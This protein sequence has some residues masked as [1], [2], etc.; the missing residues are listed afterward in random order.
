MPLPLSSA[1]SVSVP[2]MDTSPSVGCLAA[3]PCGPCLRTVFPS[4]L[5]GQS[6]WCLRPSLR[7]RRAGVIESLRCG[8]WPRKAYSPVCSIS[9]PHPQFTPSLLSSF[10]ECPSSIGIQR[11]RQCLH[12]SFDRLAPATAEYHPLPSAPF[13]VFVSLVL[14]LSPLSAAASA[15]RAACSSF[16]VDLLSSADAGMCPST[17]AILVVLCMSFP[18]F[19]R[20]V[21][22]VRSQPG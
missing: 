18:S 13:P 11:F 12:D 20:V 7:S 5:S 6:S 19:V 9:L 14:S 22:S 4:P 8:C 2:T 21:V 15:A 17:P 10:W 16:S 1:A 3:S